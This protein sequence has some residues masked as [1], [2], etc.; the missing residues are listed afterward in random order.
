MNDKNI[1][2]KSIYD[3][4]SLFE[5]TGLALRDFFNAAEM[6]SRNKALRQ[7]L[8]ES[9]E[10]H[11]DIWLDIEYDFNALFVGPMA[12][13]AAPYASVYIDDEPMVMGPTTLGVREFL[14]SIGL[15]V[16]DENGVPDDHVSFEL[17][18][19]V[20]LSAHARQSPQY[21]DAL[22]RF[23]TGHVELWLPTFIE[24]INNKAKTSAIK[25]V[26]NRMTNWLDELKA[27]VIL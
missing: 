14:H 13:L 7:L 2:T 9:A 10:W 1:F 3:A 15:F 24:K 22:T 6:T 26:A 8:P 4:L 11:D 20:M 16:D 17:E 5:S 27:R 19:I 25:S 21:H 12:P 23:T 18:L